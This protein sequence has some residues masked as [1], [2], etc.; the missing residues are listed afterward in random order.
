MKKN[1]KN[2]FEL[3]IADSPRGSSYY[4]A[5]VHSAIRKF[6][7]DPLY[8]IED[9]TYTIEVRNFTEKFVVVKKTTIITKTSVKIK[10]QK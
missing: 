1:V 10:K 4:A 7:N 3:R 9:G 8:H 6:L 5:N 2:Y